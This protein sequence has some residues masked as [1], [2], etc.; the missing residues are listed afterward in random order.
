MRYVKQLALDKEILTVKDVA[1]ALGSSK[2]AVYEMISSGR[3]KATNLGARMIR[4]LRSDVLAMLELQE[5]IIAPKIKD[6]RVKVTD[7]FIALKDGYRINEIIPAFGKTRD[8]LYIYLKRNNVPR[9]KIGKEI[10]LS[11][12]AVDELYRKFKTPKPTGLNKEI[13]DNLKL[14]KRAFK[15]RECYSIAE[16]VIR[17]G[18]ARNLLYGILNRRK[19]PRIREGRNIYVPK[20]VVDKIFLNLKKRRIVSKV[21]LRQKAISKGRNTLYLDIYPPIPHPETWILT[22]KYYLKM[23]VYA[24][25]STGL[26][27]EY[28][29]ATMGLAEYIRAKRQIDVQYFRFNFLLKDMLQKD[30]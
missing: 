6:K 20:K 16:C 8:A 11:K 29:K 19:V 23:Y 24:K 17:F 21:T 18:K 10:V 4:I 25:P 2:V 26:E 1:K 9:E 22:R 3:L 27:R 7:D 5:L 28:N 13:E 12:V 15:I 30:L 14:S